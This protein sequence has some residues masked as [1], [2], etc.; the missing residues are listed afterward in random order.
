MQIFQPIELAFQNT[1]CSSNH[2]QAIGE[3]QLRSLVNR[4]NSL[5]GLT[6]LLSCAGEAARSP[7]S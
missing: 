6:H 2:N 3:E 4:G 5:R 7:R 1:Y